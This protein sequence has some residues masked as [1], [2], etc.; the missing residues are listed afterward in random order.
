VSDII[1]TYQARS[2]PKERSRKLRFIYDSGSPWTFVK[3]SVAMRMKAVLELPEPRIFSGLGDGRFSGTHIMQLE[4]K[5]LDIWVHNLCYIVDD[6]VLEPKYDVLIGH[7]F[8]QRYDIVLK[9]K[10]RD[11]VISRDSLLMG[12]RVRKVDAFWDRI[13]NFEEL[14]EAFDEVDG[15]IKLVKNTK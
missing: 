14:K 5:L 2:T 3:K 12:L 11:V 13:I 1:K 6:E 7:D 15:Y 4:I 9:P 10:K 8:I